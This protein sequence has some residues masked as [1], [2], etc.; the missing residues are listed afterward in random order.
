MDVA[1]A[2]TGT[3]SL[4]RSPVEP[5][6]LLE[7]V[8]DLYSPVAEERQITVN[9]R[10]FYRGSI[11]ADAARLRQVLANL[12]DNALK[13]TPHHGNVWIEVE[14]RS[15]AEIAISF[16]DDGPGIPQEDLPRIWDRL[17]RG[18]RSRSQSRGLGL[19]LSLVKA[20]VEAH[21]GHVSAQNRPTGGAEFTVTLPAGGMADR[22]IATERVGA[23]PNGSETSAVL[24]DREG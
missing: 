12:L 16:R 19:G 15:P 11:L 24:M 10:P 7:N 17:F 3:M 21:G 5:A 2:E 23:L 6:R 8:I 22:P 13:Y 4:N 14:Q 20:V 18:D 9:L 1:E